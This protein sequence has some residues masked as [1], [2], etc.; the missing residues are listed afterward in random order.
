MATYAV[1]LLTAWP[2][3][4]TRQAE[5]HILGLPD[6]VFEAVVTY[7]PALERDREHIEERATS[8]EFYAAFR[9]VVKLA[10]PLGKAM[11]MFSPRGQAAA[12][13]SRSSA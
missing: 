2:A 8:A 5:Q 7:S 6:L 9:E 13:T 1:L 12:T 10:Y 11:A 4:L 3:L